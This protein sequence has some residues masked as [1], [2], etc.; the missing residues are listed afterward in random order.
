MI[1]EHVMVAQPR[2]VREKS[3]ENRLWQVIGKQNRDILARHRADVEYVHRQFVTM[4]DADDVHMTTSAWLARSI[5]EAHTISPRLWGVVLD[6]KRPEITLDIGAVWS[7]NLSKRGM[8][9]LVFEDRL[10]E[11]TLRELAPHFKDGQRAVDN[12]TGRV[13]KSALVPLAGLSPSHSLDTRYPSLAQAQ[14]EV[15]SAAMENR[16]GEYW[17]GGHSPG[18]LQYLRQ[19]GFDTPDP[20]YKKIAISLG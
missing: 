9:L 4:Y 19:L 11:R 3:R 16:R 13:T 7:V 12:T 20:V 17:R 6:V 8:E 1:D 2:T 18:V 14:F 5:R 15:M 10:D